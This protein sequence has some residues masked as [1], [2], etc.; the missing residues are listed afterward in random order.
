MF[1]KDKLENIKTQS[2]KEALPL[3]PPSRYNKEPSRNPTSFPRSRIYNF[4]TK[5]GRFF[6][7]LLLLT[8]K[9]ISYVITLF[10]N[11]VLH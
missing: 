8:M 5:L 2:R 10:Y 7:L 9:T 3:I 11:I 6:N 4:R 1:M